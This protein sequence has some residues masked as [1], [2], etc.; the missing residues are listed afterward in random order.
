[1]NLPTSNNPAISPKDYDQEMAGAVASVYSDWIDVIA[2]G[3]LVNADNS[4]SR[5]TAFAQFTQTFTQLIRTAGIYTG[6]KLR[7]GY[8]SNATINQAAVIMP[9]GIDANQLLHPLVNKNDSDSFTFTI[10]NYT[11]DAT[12]FRYT[13]P[14][15]TEYFDL[16]GSPYFVIGVK[17][18]LTLSVG[19]AALC[20][21]QAKFF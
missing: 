1:M 15:S 17:T 2:A 13:C 12:G 18:G 3:G 5:I 8:P 10:G 14:L 7:F 6:V 4:G 20:K 19:T 9:F 16:D 21:V 11:Q